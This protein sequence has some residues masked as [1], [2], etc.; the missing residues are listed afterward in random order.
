MTQTIL[1]IQAQLLCVVLLAILFL[2]LNHYEVGKQKRIKWIY[3]LSVFAVVTDLLCVAFV[4]VC[5]YAH[6]L[7]AA[8]VGCIGYLWFVHCVRRR[9]RVL[10]QKVWFHIFAI[11]PTIAR[12]K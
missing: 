4:Q 2:F 5:A 3:I 6:V 8:L 10:V 1:Y 7:Y 12:E 11:L 9:Y